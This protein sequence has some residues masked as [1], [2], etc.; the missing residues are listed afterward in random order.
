MSVRK[1]V[2]QNSRQIDKDMRFRQTDSQVK[3]QTGRKTE[4]RQIDR[5]IHRLK[6]SLNLYIDYSTSKEKD[7][8]AIPKYKL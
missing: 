7:G 6:Y 1:A 3:K 4:V 8:H 2:R 5:Q